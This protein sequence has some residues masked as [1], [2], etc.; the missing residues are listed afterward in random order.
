[1]NDKDEKIL[2]EFNSKVDDIFAILNAIRLVSNESDFK[3]WLE[4]EHGIKPTVEVFH[5][6]QFFTETLI[7]CLFTSVIYGSELPISEDYVFSRARFKGVEL[8]KIPNTCE[9][10]I[11]LKNLN[12]YRKSITNARNWDELQESLDKFKKDFIDK[13]DKIYDENVM[14]SSKWKIEKK[15]ALTYATMFFVYIYLNNTSKFVP[16]GYFVSVL[17]QGIKEKEKKFEGYKYALQFVWYQLLGK[18]GYQKTSL[19]NL[20]KSDKWS[21]ERELFPKEYDGKI[22][23]FSE[24]DWGSPGEATEPPVE[25]NDLDSYFSKV[26]DEIITPIEKRLGMNLGFSKFFRL[27][28]KISKD[29]L[30]IFLKYEK[31]AELSE[32]DK[33][34]YA[35][36]WYPIEL[37]DS[38]KSNIFSGVPTFIELLVG[39][40]ETKK[41]FGIDEKAYVCKFIHPNREV[42]GNDYSYGVLIEAFGSSGISDYSGWVLFYDCCGDYSGFSGS[43]HMMAERIIELYKNKGLTEVREMTIDKQKFKVYLADRIAEDKKEEIFEELEEISTKRAKADVL[44]EIKG[45]V[46]ELLTYYTLTKGYPNDIVDWSVK[47]DGGELDIFL[48]TAIELIVIECKTDLNTRNLTECIKK[49]ER[50]VK[51]YKTSKPKRGEFWFWERPHPVR[52]EM[53]KSKN[54]DFQVFSELMESNPIWKNKNK[55]KIKHIFKKIAK[56]AVI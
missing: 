14:V 22:I 9:K 12:D 44:G 51:N 15:D 11:F 36:L 30:E 34:D 40:A 7:R 46:L 21:E 37:I 43:E 52:I 47:K 35:L 45:I 27:K 17:R 49:L 55:D 19:K 39:S 25:R 2:E 16:L 54:I 32:R 8:S 26:Q 29:L 33:L 53:L 38:S 3:K 24:I 1:M 48:E 23:D 41:L 4:A 10:T 50:K 31:D 20:H 13:F 5:G 18:D 28:K 6:Y 42:N 56:R